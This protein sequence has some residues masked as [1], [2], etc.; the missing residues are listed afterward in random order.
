MKREG[1]R[2][3]ARSLRSSGQICGRLQKK[4]IKALSDIFV[5]IILILRFLTLLDLYK[6]CVLR[7]SKE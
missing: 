7:R 3:V 6:E 4:V 2:E 5:I 1:I